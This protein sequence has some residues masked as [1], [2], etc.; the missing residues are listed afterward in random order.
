MRGGTWKPIPAQTSLSE[1]GR[2]V[3][4]YHGPWTGLMRPCA[5]H[6]GPTRN[7]LSIGHLG[8]DRGGRDGDGFERFI[9]K[10][11][12]ARNSTLEATL[13]CARPEGSL[14]PTQCGCS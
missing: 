1:P 4:V 11:A 13:D 3:G 12:V 2:A 10:P 5:F 14:H 8:F 7:P 6:P 9:L